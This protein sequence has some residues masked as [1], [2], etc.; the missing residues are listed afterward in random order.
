MD[1][2]ERGALDFREFA[3]G[4]YL[5][6]AIQSCSITSVPSTV[7]PELHDLFLDPALLDLH[8]TS[9]RPPH[10]HR[11]KTSST[12]LSHSSSS[13]SQILLGSK[14]PLAPVHISPEY[15]SWDISPTERVG[16]DKN[17]HKLDLDCKGYIEGKTAANFMLK[18]KLSP[19]DLARIWCV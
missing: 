12:S 15:D 5:I 6:Q 11:S 1:V 17:F 19:P 18:Y 9:K 7:P 8:P 16:A 14:T 3:M 10:L 13:R 4:M 2:T